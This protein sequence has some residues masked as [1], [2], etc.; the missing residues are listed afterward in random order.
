MP[1]INPHTGKSF[2]RPLQAAQ[3][4]LVGTD[5][6]DE[7]KY[8]NITAGG[9]RDL[10]PLEFSKAQ[11]MSYYEHQR[12][13]LARRMIEILM[14]FTTGEDM[15]VKV[16][17]KKRTKDYGSEDT[18]KKEAQQIWDEFWENPVND[19]EGEFPVIVQDT[20]LA[21]ETVLPAFVNE[22]NGE[23]LIGYMDPGHIKDVVTLPGNQRI[24]DTLI[25]RGA[26]SAEDKP[27]KVIRYDT[28]PKSPTFKELRGDVFYFRV[29]YVMSQKRG[30][31]ELVE[32]LDWL[33]AFEQFLFAVLKGFDARNAHFFDVTMEGV[34]KDELDKISV[35]PP[36]QGEVKLHNEKV[37]W[38]IKA[39]DLKSVD[40]TAATKLIKN[41][42]TGTKGFPDM[43]MGDASDSNLATA[44]VMTQPTMR[45]LKRKQK[46]VK[47]MVKSIAAFVMQQ[48]QNVNKLTL[49]QD[50]F[51]DVEVSMFDIERK[52]AAVIGSAFVQL[53]TALKVAVQ[54]N[55][56]TNETAKKVIDG[57]VNMLGV[58]I[59]S[60]ET[61]QKVRETNKTQEE[62]DILHD[63]PPVT[64]FLNDD[65]KAKN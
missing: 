61:I 11:E 1:S 2:T 43:W 38:D 42:I 35:A 16:K 65:T 6:A 17:I 14:D 39:P 20:F 12:Y 8:R 49:E 45:M 10:K 15:A 63:V 57:I 40:A 26:N 32:Y 52:D 36:G 53:G 5:Q 19:L 54:S 28:D 55:W 29:N 41:F 9:K 22:A 4:G 21:G 59:D 44:Q 24:I 62:E 31:G 37:I 23:V 25:M 56:I 27:F 18:Q 46:V 58:E 13:P 64:P 33:D 47:R 50:E 3:V 7:G 30:Y 48:A 34:E 60:N 51:I